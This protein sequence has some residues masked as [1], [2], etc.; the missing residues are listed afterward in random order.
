MTFERDFREN[1]P[2][3][4]IGAQLAKHDKLI[5]ELLARDTAGTVKTLQ[6]FELTGTATEFDFPSIPS[7]YRDLQFE[8]YVRSNKPAV[9]F[10][11]IY[12]EI[13]GDTGANYDNLAWQAFH[14]STT[15]T[16]EGLGVA[17]GNASQ[18]MGFA[19]AAATPANYFSVF[20]VKILNYAGTVG[21]KNIRTVGLAPIN[22]TSGNLRLFD[23]GGVWRSTAAINRVRFYLAA[24]SFIVG[25]RAS[26]FGIG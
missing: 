3:S 5:R 25:S 6:D 17:P 16:N 24:N 14:P 1:G 4:Q 8:L 19:T 2:F 20:T 13:N 15:F 7:T 12:W 23:G 21:Y 11:S 18:L 9:T 26:L 10:D 22:N